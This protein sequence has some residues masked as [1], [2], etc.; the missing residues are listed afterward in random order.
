MLIVTIPKTM[1]FSEGM[2]LL[3]M[4]PMGYD[5]YY[6]NELFHTLGETG[7]HAYL[8]Y[9]IPVDMIYP[10]LFGLTYFLILAYFL[11]KISRLKSPYF[12]LCLLPIFAGVSDYLENFGI[13]IMLNNYPEIKETVVYTTNIFS[14]IKSTTTTI[15]FIALIVV[16]IIL[17]INVIK[18]RTI[19]NNM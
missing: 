13:I 15:Y 16:L 2:K 9:Q 19:A 17:G 7:R 6:V 12:Y 3:D 18:R 11:K 10:L 14:I 1:N 5:W 4:M 8:S